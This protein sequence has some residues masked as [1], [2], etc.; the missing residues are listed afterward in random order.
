MTDSQLLVDQAIALVDRF[1]ETK[2]IKKEK[3]L[4]TRPDGHYVHIEKTE[5]H[6]RTRRD[7]TLRGLISELRLRASL[8]DAQR[9]ILDRYEQKPAN[10]V[11]RRNVL[12]LL[13]DE[14]RMLLQEGSD[15]GAQ[16][17]FTSMMETLTQGSMKPDL[18]IPFPTQDKGKPFEPSKIDDVVSLL[19]I[20]VDLLDEKTQMETGHESSESF[21]FVSD[22]LER[23]VTLKFDAECPENSLEKLK[24]FLDTEIRKQ[25]AN[26]ANWRKSRGVQGMEYRTQ[27]NGLIPSHEEDNL[28]FSVLDNSNIKPQKRGI[29]VEYRLGTRLV[30]RQTYYEEAH[31]GRA[32]NITYIVYGDA[33]DEILKEFGV[34]ME[35]V[36]DTPS[37]GL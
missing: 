17:L 21:L 9:K 16:S 14:Q 22:Y 6:V 8:T 29:R 13:N 23:R 27:R 11:A 5:K 36:Q 15:A 30:Q 24:N 31:K 33:A 2:K 10:E 32:G 28:A 19:R 25:L 4:D 26:P 7:I 1:I 37:R 18:S 12:A 20:A 35:K 3:G 34:D